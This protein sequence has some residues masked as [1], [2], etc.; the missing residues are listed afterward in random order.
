MSATMTMPGCANGRPRRNLSDTID[1]LD[2]MIDGLAEA[3]PATIRDTLKEAV[4]ASVAE[5]VK[6]A[7]VHV[8]AS[9]ELA[10]A[11]A[12]P[13]R[14]P[15][16]RQRLAAALAKARAAV[17]RRVRWLAQAVAPSPRRLRRGARLA[18]NLRRPLV[19]AAAAGAVVGFAAAWTPHWVAAALTGVGTAGLSLLVQ[20]GLWA[21]RS[22]AAILAG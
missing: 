9:R 11:L 5:G 22:L 18:W 19:V 13:A 15:T 3:I 20:A 21:R 6:A 8:L 10:G 1:R 12:A 17:T 16:L 4:A 2:E 14:T 7:V